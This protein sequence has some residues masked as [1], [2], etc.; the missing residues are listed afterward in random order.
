MRTLDLNTP[1]T[2]EEALAPFDAAEL[3]KEAG[4]FAKFLIEKDLSVLVPDSASSDLILLRLFHDKLESVLEL[5][6][7]KVGRG[8]GRPT[9]LYRL[10]RHYKVWKQSQG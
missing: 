1:S 9:R 3:Q 8:R 10:A 4:Q 6:K 2:L 7:D 5:H